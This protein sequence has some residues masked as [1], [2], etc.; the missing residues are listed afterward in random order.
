[1]KRLIVLLFV[2]TG[3]CSCS[4]ETKKSVFIEKESF[5]IT[6][7]GK[8]IDR[9]TL[10]NESEMKVQI[11]TYGGIITNIYVPNKDG[12]Q[13]D[14]V[15]GYD[16]LSDYENGSPYF[17]ALIGR[18]GNR[19]ADGKFKLDGTEYTLVQNNGKN[20]L[21]GGTK[22]FDKVVWDATSRIENEKAILQLNYLSNDLEEGYPGNLNVEVIYALTKD[23]TLEV[24]YKAATDKK[25]VINLTQH[26]YFNLSEE[27]DIMNH[28][29]MLNAPSYLPVDETLIPTGEIASV[30]GTPFD[31]TTFKSIG[32][33][34]EN[35]N[36][37][38][39]RGLGYDHCWVLEN[40]KNGLQL[41]AILKN[42][43]SGIQMEIFTD[44]PA[45]Q[46]YSGNFLDGSNPMKDSESFYS[47]RSGLCLETQHFPNSPNQDSFPSTVLNPSEIY[48]TKT[49][50]KFSNEVR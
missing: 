46:F 16:N 27:K 50:Y 34:I 5:G 45:I 33:D 31:F 3:L 15:L 12:N 48:N 43:S 9:F 18:Y 35:E 7:N 26:S 49:L 47:Y 40:S 19:I 30:N 13:T 22:G 25:T 4:Q 38:L 39:E 2:F 42:K 21:H 29:L 17:G 1:M 11:L 37:Q 32:R 44:Q 14:I 23:N 10:S 6:V 24:K 41:A 20:H 28:E 36:I 8:K